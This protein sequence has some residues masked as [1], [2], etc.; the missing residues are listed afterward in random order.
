MIC[1]GAGFAA[2]YGITRAYFSIIFVD[3]YRMI[4]KEYEK[5]AE[6]KYNLE[7]LKILKLCSDRYT[8]VYDGQ[9][10]EKTEKAE[11]TLAWIYWIVILML[12]CV[13]GEMLCLANNFNVEYS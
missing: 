10:L 7:T 1:T 8:N 2:A 3:I 6:N 4:R 9:V 11:E 13:A 5:N 12:L